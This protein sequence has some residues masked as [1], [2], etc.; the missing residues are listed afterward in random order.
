[1]AEKKA[2][3]YE[4]KTLVR[5]GKT[6]V[7]TSAEHEAKLRWDGYRTAPSAKAK[8]ADTNKQ[9]PSQG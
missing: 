6:V 7:T 2:R 8:P 3:P 9:K 1:M 4:P 5:D